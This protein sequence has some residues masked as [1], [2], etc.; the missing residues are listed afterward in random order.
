[1]KKKIFISRQIRSNEINLG[2]Q[3][4]LSLKIQTHVHLMFSVLQDKI[5]RKNCEWKFGQ[6]IESNV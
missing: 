1:M 5:K 6:M 4:G 3:A 2:T